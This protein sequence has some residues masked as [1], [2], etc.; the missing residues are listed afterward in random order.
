M[1]LVWMVPR[2]TTNPKKKKINIYSYVKILTGSA[3]AVSMFYSS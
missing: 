2:L 1:A 3:P